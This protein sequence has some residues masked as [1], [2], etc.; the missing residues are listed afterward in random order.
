[1][2]IF[3]NCSIMCDLSLE[4]HY[5]KKGYKL[6]AGVDEA[7]RGPLAGPVVAACIALGPS[8]KIKG[9]LKKVND[10]KKLSVKTRNEAFREFSEL[11]PIGIGIC[12]HSEID[13]INILQA[14]LSAMR[15][16]I[17]NLDLKP[18]LALLDG[19]FTIKGLGIR[20]LAVIKGDS[21]HFSIAA[22]SIAA[23]VTRDKIM[24]ELHEQYPQYGFFENKGYPTADHLKK[25]E[26][27]GP[28]PIHRLTFAPVK[29]KISG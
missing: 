1:M 28:C 3:V 2:L 19:K 20:Q 5:F 25:L 14:S 23:K 21:R 18:D 27:Y 9:I 22:A 17:E 16:A 11:L 13:S 8:L 10:S 6:I 15:K 7:G 24:L 26:K 29:R 4:N 12:D